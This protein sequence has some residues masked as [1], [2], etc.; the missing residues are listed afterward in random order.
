MSPVPRTV[1]PRSGGWC[2][3]PEDSTE[4]SPAEPGQNHRSHLLPP[5]QRTDDPRPGPDP[6]PTRSRP[7]CPVQKLLPKPT[8][9]GRIQRTSSILGG[10]S[11]P[12]VRVG[13]FPTR[14]EGEEE[15][16]FGAVADE[17]RPKP[18]RSKSLQNSEDASPRA[19]KGGARARAKHPG[20][21]R[22]GGGAAG[23]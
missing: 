6:V 2:R 4:H 20:K 12:E 13:T 8:S 17:Q 23:R 21:C 18:V 11:E 10:S 3:W 9:S 19:R 5:N 1:G 22:R 15:V 7:G 16:R 14:D